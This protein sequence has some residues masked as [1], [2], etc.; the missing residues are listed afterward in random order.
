MVRPRRARRAHV[1][2]TAGGDEADAELPAR[3]RGAEDGRGTQWRSEGAV[4]TAADEVAT[5]AAGFFLATVIA[6][7]DN[8]LS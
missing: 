8:V 2:V 7:V 5:D 3:G 6:H 4:R 1:A